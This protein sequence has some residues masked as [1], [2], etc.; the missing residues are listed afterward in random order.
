LLA[1]H[2]RRQTQQRERGAVESMAWW[3]VRRRI[4]K[5]DAGTRAA[6]GRQQRPA[7]RSSLAR[8]AASARCRCSFT[9]SPPAC[10]H[11]RWPTKPARGHDASP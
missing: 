1:R 2:R 6:V 8:S 10:E 3:L 11:A 4:R 9:T 7:R 5:A